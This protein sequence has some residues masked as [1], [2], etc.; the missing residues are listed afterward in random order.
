MAYINSNPYFR[1]LVQIQEDNAKNRIRKND[2]LMVQIDLLI[3]NYTEKLGRE[4]SG[5]QGQ[6]TLENQESLN[7]PALF[8]LKNQLAAD[9]ELKK[10]EQQMNREPITI[11]NFGNPH[12]LD[13]PLLRK[14][15]VFFPLLFIGAFLII[16]LIRYLNRNAEGL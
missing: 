16:S 3:E 8:Q 2:S 9:T 15:L 4:Q 6:L 14:N 12:K 13:K 10:L 7:V 5:A 11:V 1:Q